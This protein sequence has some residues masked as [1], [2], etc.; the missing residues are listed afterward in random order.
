MKNSLKIKSSIFLALLL[1]MTVFILGFFILREID[2]DQ[3]RQQETFLKDASTT[4]QEYVEQVILSEPSYQN[5]FSL[6]GKILF[7]KREA[8]TTHLEMKTGMRVELFINGDNDEII[9]DRPF[10]FSKNTDKK[11]FQYAHENKIAF[12][13]E[14]NTLYYAAPLDNGFDGVIG[15]AYPLKEDQLFLQRIEHFFIQIGTLVVILS[16]LIAYFYFHRITNE[17]LRL[18]E[19][20]EQIEQGNYQAITPTKRKDELGKL[21]QGIH[22]MSQRIEAHVRAMEQKQAALNLAIDKLKKLENQQKTFIGNI[23]HEFKTPLS[24]IL[25]YMD[26]LELYEDDPNLVQDARGNVKKEAQRLYNLVEKVLQLASFEKYDFE[27]QLEKIESAEIL[28]ELCDRMKGKAQKFDV[29][30]SADLQKATLW[31]DKESFHLI[32]INLLDNAIKYNIPGGKIVAKSEIKENRLITQIIDTGIGIPTDAYEKVFEPFFTV[33]KDRSKQSGGT[34]LGLA[35][36]KRLVEEQQ[37]TI[38]I[39]PAKNHVGT[40]VTLSFPLYVELNHFKK[41]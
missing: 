38:T 37:G 27:L 33:S 34:G 6:R 2:Q 4:A 7:K 17:I 22:S 26:L 23:T 9:A 36:V 12:K 28:E 31:F 11:M 16:F 19:A 8:I 15:F 41:S 40:E 14:G 21:R 13:T 25:A 24:I 10:T 20:S 29:S 18:K 5:N 32:F 1:S 3:K 30:I 39:H 35:L